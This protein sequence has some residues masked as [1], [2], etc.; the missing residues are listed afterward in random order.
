M[1]VFLSIV[2]GSGL[3]MIPRDGPRSVLVYCTS[4]QCTHAH[5]A[6]TSTSSAQDL[7]DHL[8]DRDL[9]I[10]DGKEENAHFLE[11]AVDGCKIVLY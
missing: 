9:D 8:F 3:K 7:R 4:V 1:R 10:Y 11:E 5:K 2:G 6:R